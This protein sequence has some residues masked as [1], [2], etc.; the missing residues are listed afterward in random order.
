MFHVPS[1]H[2]EFEGGGVYD[3][4]LAAL[5]AL[6]FAVAAA[7]ACSIPVMGWVVCLI[8]WLIALAIMG[9]GVAVALNDKGDPTDVNPDLNQL[10]RLNDVLVVKG[11]WVYDS[12]HSGSNELHPIKACNRIARWRDDWDYHWPADFETTVLKPWCAA[13]EQADSPVTRAAQQ[14]PVHRWDLHP[15]IDGCDPGSGVIR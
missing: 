11:L 3:I 9:A 4:L 13:L 1:L 5:A 15:S 7:V 6:G 2:C 14:D 8:L 10:E 12:Q